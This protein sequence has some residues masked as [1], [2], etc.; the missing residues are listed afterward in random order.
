MERCFEQGMEG[1]NREHSLAGE[2][3][4]RW[5]F[6][7]QLVQIEEFLYFAQYIDKPDKELQAQL[8]YKIRGIGE[9]IPYLGSFDRT[10]PTRESFSL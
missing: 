1:Y 2:W 5:P 8:N 4:E 3:L 9:D 6:F 10:L 7:L